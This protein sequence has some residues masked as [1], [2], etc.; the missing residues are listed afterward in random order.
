MLGIVELHPSQWDRIVLG[1]L[2]TGEHDR[3]VAAQAGGLVHRAR[4]DAPVLQ[5]E[6]GPS[7]EEGLGLVQAMEPGK[8]M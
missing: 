7:N 8:A 4:V 2:D 3:L 5:V 1:R 6:L